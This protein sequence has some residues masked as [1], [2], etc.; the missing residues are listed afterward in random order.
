MARK[1]NLERRE[2]W[3]QRIERQRQS[4][5]TVSEFSRRKGFPQR[6]SIAGSGRSAPTSSHGETIATPSVSQGGRIAGPVLVCPTYGRDLR[7]TAVGACASYPLDRT[8]VDRRYLDPVT[9]AEPGRPA[10]RA[11]CVR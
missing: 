9:A 3:R 11:A 8:D 1:L 10:D 2:T 4:G 7:A 5:L 6:A